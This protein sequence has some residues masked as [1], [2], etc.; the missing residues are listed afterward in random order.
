MRL[1]FQKNQLSSKK[2]GLLSFIDS[3]WQKSFQAEYPVI[4][5]IDSSIFYHKG[6]NSVTIH[7]PDFDYIIEP[8]T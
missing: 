6:N 2:L 4:F 7:H 3:P 8:V 1:E 5:L